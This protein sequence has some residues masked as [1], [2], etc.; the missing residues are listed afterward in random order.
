MRFKAR[1]TLVFISALSV[2]VATPRP[3]AS[4]TVVTPGED[5]ASIALAAQVGDVIEL[6][7]GTYELADELVFANSGVTLR[8]QTDGSSRLVFNNAFTPT[9]DAALI[10][11][12]GRS[13][14]TLQH[15]TLDGQNRAGGA[16]YGVYAVDGSGHQLKNLAV[17]Q[18]ENPGLFGPVGV[19]F[20]GGVNDS[21]VRDSTFTQIGVDDAFGS[22]IRVHGDSDRNLIEGNTID[23]TGRG[24]IFALGNNDNAL[25]ASTLDNLIIRNNTVTN[26]ALASSSTESFADLGIEVQNDIRDVLIEDN[27][28]DRR[29]SLD[30]VQRAAVRRNVV[31]Q[32]DNNPA[33]TA[34][35][36]YGIEVVDVQDLVATDNQVRGDV[37]F[38]IS[39]SG[40][41]DTRHALF[42]DNVIDEATTFGVQIQGRDNPGAA[43]V[44]ED[45]YFSNNEI[46]DTLGGSDALFT[47]TGDGIRFNMA[48]DDITLDGNTLTGHAGQDLFLN[49]TPAGSTVALSDNTTD[50]SYTDGNGIDVLTP[51]LTQETFSANLGQTITV[52]FDD[53]AGSITHVLW[54]LGVG[55][56]LAADDA[57]LNL[58]PSTI[59]ESR[60]LLVVAWDDAGLAD[61]AIINVVPEPALA[62]LGI[63]GAA[64]LRLRPSRRSTPAPSCL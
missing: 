62:L 38:G 30:N 61:T 41:G 47:G 19:Y 53:L 25:G 24:G 18:L 45:L 15:L 35:G 46:T 4:Q 51:P 29:V 13:D 9:N 44:A 21:A 54:D 36:D 20:N 34:V 55:I 43:G 7:T 2:C 48:F 26:S 37:H 49:A 28:V 32:A 31:T 40:D 59:G 33:T 56:P 6:G 39:I 17:E 10:N 23:R 42:A 50:D 5:L 11:L 1:A 27:V 57:T 64:T 8:G 3:S 16:T 52:A 14:I 63:M 58:D 12:A 22:G 60:S